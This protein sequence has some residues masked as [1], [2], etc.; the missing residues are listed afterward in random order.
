MDAAR[1]EDRWNHTARLVWLHLNLNRNKD[2]EPV[3]FFDC[4]PFLE[5]P[6]PTEAEIEDNW[7]IFQR[8]M[9][10]EEPAEQPHQDPP[11]F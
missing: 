10:S 4:H 6:E 7:R 8:V 5:K 9:S 3:S 1:S 2:D 11:P